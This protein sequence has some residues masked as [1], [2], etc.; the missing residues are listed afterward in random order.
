MAMNRR[1]LHLRHPDGFSS[2]MFERF[3]AGCRLFQA[4]VQTTLSEWERFPAAGDERIAG[5]Y[6]FLPPELSSDGLVASLPIEGQ[7]T[8]GSRAELENGAAYLLLAFFSPEFKQRLQEG[9]TES[10]TGQMSTS[11]REPLQPIARVLAVATP[12]LPGSG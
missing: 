12:R 2:E 6:R 7:W 9:L 8:L 3:R 10:V 11:W 1:V 4:H 5:D